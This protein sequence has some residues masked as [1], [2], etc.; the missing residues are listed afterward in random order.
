METLGKIRRRKLIKGES[1]SAIARALK[2]SRNTVRKY[3]K[4]DVEPVYQR[5]SQ[6]APKL[7]AFQDRP[8]LW[9]K[10][11][12]ARPVG[13]RRTARRLFED[14]QSEG[15]RGAYDSV[16][17]FVKHWKAARPAP[18]DAFVPLVFAP[19]E[20]CQFDWSHEH[21]VLG[22]AVQGVKVAHFRLPHSRQLFVVAYPRESQERVFDAHA[23]A[24]AFFGGVPE[25][26]IYDNPRTIVDSLY[27]GK[28]RRFNRRF[29][30]LASH[31]LFEPVA[32]TPGA[33]GEKGQVENQVG[34]VREWLFTPTPKFT[35]LAALN[36]W[37][38][39]RCRELAKRPH[40]GLKQHTIAEIFAQ[41]QPRLR[42]LTAV[43]DGY[44]ALTCGSPPPAW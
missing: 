5:Q 41:E 42:P 18:A 22:G 31:Y 33:G 44:L 15:Y 21:V 6:P 1:I 35:D 40:P 32:C 14:L 24:F 34:N 19:G 17:R 30:A 23:R 29:L 8:A 37:L 10:Q 27:R 39:T 26:L 20:A 16:Q 13:Q 12:A 7:G 25:R 11:D 3:L 9:L 4:V 28:E 43:F 36:L 38:A 2:L